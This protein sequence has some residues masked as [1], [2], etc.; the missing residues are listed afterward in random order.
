MSL[1]SDEVTRC[2]FIVCR[3]ERDGEPHL[4]LVRDERWGDLTL[5]G[6]HEDPE[7]QRE[8]E[9]TARREALEEL[10]SACACTG[11]RLLSLTD[12]LPFGPTWSKSAG[13]SKRY[14]FK[15]YAILFDQ[16]P[17]LREGV[18]EAGF[19]LEF[20][21]E[22]DLPAKPG[23][24]NIVKL[25]LATFEGKLESVPLSWSDECDRM[26]ACSGEN[27]VGGREVLIKASCW[28]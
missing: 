9:R 5:I 1:G 6:G 18:N 26:R 22:R 13:I 16:Q 14:S 23:L 17:H 11:F 8:L 28:P 27:T 2:A 19:Q 10:G 4:L 25:F 12:E 3:L 20:V 7:D 15:F 24:S 21:K